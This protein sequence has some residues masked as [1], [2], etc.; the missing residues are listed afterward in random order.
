[1]RN[2][3]PTVVRPLKDSPAEK[4]AKAGDIILAVNNKATAN[5]SIEDIVRMVRGE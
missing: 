3:K 2:N 5:M 4:L 1:M